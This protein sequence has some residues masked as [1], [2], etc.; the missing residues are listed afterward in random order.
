MRHATPSRFPCASS[1]THR[2]KHARQHARTEP[3]GSCGRPHWTTVGKD[4]PAPSLIFCALGRWPRRLLRPGGSHSPPECTNAL[5]SMAHC[6]GTVY[7]STSWTDRAIT[8]R[9]ERA[10]CCATALP[11][12]REKGA[13]HRP[14]QSRTTA[15]PASRSAS[16]SHLR[17]AAELLPV[18]ALDS[19]HGLTTNE[20]T[21]AQSN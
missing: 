20:R 11:R 21:A 1:A 13:G 17:R 15:E 18:L 2:P 14:P 16:S 3:T 9:H 19:C 12:H 6:S 7:R 5:N 8:V 10:I 4:R